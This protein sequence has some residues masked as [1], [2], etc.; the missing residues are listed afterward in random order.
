METREKIMTKA[1]ELFKR[2]G[3]RSVTMDEVAGQCGVS[4]KTVYQYF[5]DKESLVDV[6]MKTMIDRAEAN[7][8]ACNLTADNA[9]HEIFMAMDMVQEMFDGVNPTMMYDLRKYHGT[10]FARLNDH[11]Q[12]FMYSTIKKNIERGIAEELY[13]TDMN[14]EIVTIFQ[15]HTMTLV[16][17]EDIFSKTKISIIEIDTELTLFSLHGMATTKGIKQIEKY[18]QQRLKLQH[19]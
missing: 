8:T 7:C 11:K 6:I 2:Y 3:M 18:K 13:R 10:A 1:F 19:L 16:F 4:K 14:I 15:L 9:V 5:E 12:K 17:E